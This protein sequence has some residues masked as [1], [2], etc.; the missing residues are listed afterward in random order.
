VREF[1]ISFLGKWCWRLLQEPE[2]LW[3]IVFAAKYGM[4]VVRW[5]VVI[6]ELLVGCKTLIA[7]GVGVERWFNNILKMI[8]D[9]ERILFWKDN[10]VDGILLK[11]QFGR[12]FD[13]C[14]DKEVSMADICRLG[15]NLGGNGW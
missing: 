11:S 14:L 4:R 8:G 10:W 2:D 7:L 13:L 9:G 5:I 15:W 3:F 1:N 6:V 12:L